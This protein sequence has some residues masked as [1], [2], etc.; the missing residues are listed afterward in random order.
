[1][2]MSPITAAILGTLPTTVI[3]SQRLRIVGMRW[4]TKRRSPPSQTSMVAEGDSHSA[5]Q[6]DLF[7]HKADALLDTSPE[8]VLSPTITKQDAVYVAAWHPV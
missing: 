2:P 5:A 1:M 7:R 4:R 6:N 3:P 8:G